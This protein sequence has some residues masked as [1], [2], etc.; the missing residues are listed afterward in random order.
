MLDRMG[1]KGSKPASSPLAKRLQKGAYNVATTLKRGSNSFFAKVRGAFTRK[2]PT[3]AERRTKAKKRV[4][5]LERLNR[6]PKGLNWLRKGY[7]GVKKMFNK[8]SL[9]NRIASAKRKSV[10]PRRA[11]ALF[12]RKAVRNSAVLPRSINPG[13]NINN[14]NFVSAVA[15]NGLRR[16]GN[17]GAYTTVKSSRSP[18]TPGGRW[19]WSPVRGAHV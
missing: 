8:K 9:K 15:G 11:N 16:I 19:N 6:S 7:Y 5:M 13:F 2:A 14:N 18:R 4:N 1:A 17:A 10:L 3:S 12:S